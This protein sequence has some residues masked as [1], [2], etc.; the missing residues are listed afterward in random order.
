MPNKNILKQGLM[1]LL[2]LNSEERADRKVK[3]IM[4]LDDMAE[5][6]LKQTH[7][8]PLTGVKPLSACR[9]GG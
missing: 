4:Q 5:T 7:L 3:R 8:D 1:N 2:N 9:P 6:T